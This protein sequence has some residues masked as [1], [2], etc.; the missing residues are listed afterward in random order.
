MIRKKKRMLYGWYFMFQK[1]FKC[2]IVFWY[3]SQIFCYCHQLTCNLKLSWQIL[4]LL[5]LIFIQN[6]YASNLCTV[7]NI[8]QISYRSVRFQ[9][10]GQLSTWSKANK[11]LILLILLEK[12]CG[13]YL[14]IENCY[15]LLCTDISLLPNMITTPAH[16]P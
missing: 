9:C 2:R 7:P 15:S 13:N 6:I 16:L 8:W 10:T 1:Y 14:Q 12:F 11:S 5:I 4:N 3:I